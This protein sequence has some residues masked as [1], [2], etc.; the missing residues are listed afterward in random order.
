MLAKCERKLTSTCYS[1]E[2]ELLEIPIEKFEKL[3]ANS[4]FQDIIKANS[5]AKVEKRE[6]KISKAIE[7][8]LNL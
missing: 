2:C 3:L 4:D 1:A 7:V 5:V 8:Y 6:E